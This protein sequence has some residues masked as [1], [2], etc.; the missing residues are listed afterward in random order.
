MG[1]AVLLV[2]EIGKVTGLLVVLRMQ[3]YR[4]NATVIT[5]T[6]TDA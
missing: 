2:V 3:P 5:S 4:T 6:A 1:L